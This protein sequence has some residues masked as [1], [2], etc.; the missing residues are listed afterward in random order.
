MQEITREDFKV[1][2]RRTRATRG[3]CGGVA[4]GVHA[5]HDARTPPHTPLGV[6]GV[7][8]VC[9]PHAARRVAWRAGW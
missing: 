8:A 7:R 3:R 1:V 9:A 6:G 2:Q 5:P 4:N